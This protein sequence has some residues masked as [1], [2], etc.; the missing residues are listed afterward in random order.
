MIFSNQ[1]AITTTNHKSVQSMMFIQKNVIHP[2]SNKN[3]SKQIETVSN[4][5]VE[6]K[7]KK[8]KWGE[9]TWFFLHTIAEKVKVEKFSE[10]R[11][12]LLKN[13]NNICRNLPCPDCSNHAAKYLDSSN[14]NLIRTKQDLID[15]M[16]NF[17]NEINKRKG[18][19]IFPYEELSSKY[20]QANTMSIIQYFLIHFLDKPITVRMIS[21]DFYRRRLTENLKTWLSNKL[22]YFEM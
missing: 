10:I 2:I 22:D 11:L 17:H 14:F 3:T 4:T 21:N 20:S 16:Y 6:P 1:R 19:P 13:I 8:M 12:E 7:K 9:P 18:Y 15:F 5:E